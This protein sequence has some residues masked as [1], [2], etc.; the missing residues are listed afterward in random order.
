MSVGTVE[1]GVYSALSGVVDDT[2]TSNGEPVTSAIIDPV[3]RL[4]RAVTIGPM[5]NSMPPSADG[6][7]LLNVGLSSDHIVDRALRA[8]GVYTTPQLGPTY[9]GV[10]VP[11][12]GSLWPAWGTCTSAGARSNT[13]L[14]ADFATSNWGWGITDADAYFTPV[15]PG[16]VTAATVLELA[17]MVSSGHAA[18]ATIGTTLVGRAE[19]YQMTVAYDRSVRLEFWDG[20]AMTTVASLGAATGWV[21]V[22]GRFSATQ[23]VLT[24]DDGRSVTAS[25]STVAAVTT[26]AL[27]SVHIAASNGAVIGGVIVSNLPQGN[28]LGQVLGG[29]LYGGTSLN[30][31]L[32]ASPGIVAR[33]AVDL[34]AEIAD[35]TCRAWWW[36][37]D[38]QFQWMPGDLLLA[39]TPAT[40]FTARSS[41]A[42]VGWSEA[43]G[44]SYSAVTVKYESPAI[45][46]ASVRTAEVWRGGSQS[47][48]GTTEEF[49]SSPADED[50][51][52]V[53]SPTQ[54]LTGTIS[55]FNLG[56]GSWY[57]ATTDA[58][59][60]VTDPALTVTLTAITP[61][62]WKLTTVANGA[63]DQKVPDLAAIKKWKQGE[64]L[65][66]LRARYKATWAARSLTTGT[67]PA[68]AAEYEHDGGRWLQG[69]A[70]EGPQAV[71]DFLAQWLCTP[72]AKLTGI[73]LVHDG[74]V[75]VG[76]VVDIEDPTEFGVRWTVLLTA[77]EQ[78]T[79]AADQS[80]T[81]DC[82]VIS[83]VPLGLTYGELDANNTGKTYGQLDAA[84]TGRTYGQ[85]D[86]APIN[87]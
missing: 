47:T 34:I 85:F 73:R 84:N 14:S 64:A 28:Y 50:W 11:G 81:V 55:A 16:S 56:P 78:E 27:E 69:Y 8:C 9:T 23:A 86:A 70:D 26:A 21:R 76:D 4:H 30:N 25:Y 17:C 3:D 62:T 60:L 51:I 44:D 74:R 72:H 65:P 59:A 75:Q 7:P 31:K 71:G 38:G 36:T 15:G 2:S 66:V 32:V 37:E 41:L 79:S 45:A 83:A 67:G 13:S 43:A 53:G 46:R 18:D 77:V 5:S 49:I 48:Q 82:F 40:T 52:Y 12:Q 68:D 20:T 54:L 24:T 80:M 63:Y 35:A 42:S 57:G 22:A 58:G 6:G 10:S 33:N 1:A 39:R 29:R 87:A 61:A 19:H